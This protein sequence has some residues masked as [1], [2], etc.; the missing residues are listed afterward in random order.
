MPIRQKTPQKDNKGQTPKKGGFERKND[1]GK[2][3]R[4]KKGK[5]SIAKKKMD[6]RN[7]R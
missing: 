1:K 4:H 5:T 6:S 3:T 7:K 2:E